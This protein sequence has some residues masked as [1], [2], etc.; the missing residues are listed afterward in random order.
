M[1]KHGASLPPPAPPPPTAEEITEKLQPVLFAEVLPI[2]ERALSR[3]KGGVEES[4]RDSEENICKQLFSILQPAV[5]MVDTVKPVL[6]RHPVPDAPPA[7]V[8]MPPPPPP[9]QTAQHS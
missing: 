6:D 3:L 7:A 5:A 1:D 8:L 2:V 4:M 9:V